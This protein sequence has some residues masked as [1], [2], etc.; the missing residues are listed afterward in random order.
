[1]RRALAIAGLL[2]ACALLGCG[3]HGGGGSSAAC[4]SEP[5]GPTADVVFR[6][7]PGAQQVTTAARAETIA[8]LCRRLRAHDLAGRVEPAGPDRLKIVAERDAAGEEGELTAVQAVTVPM[9]LRVYDWE[10]N[11][12]GSKRGYDS[13]LEAARVASSQEPVENCAGCAS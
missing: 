6:L 3:D 11:L 12:L 5:E 13:A 1:M 7:R 9:G 2:A 8:F 4:S 10:A